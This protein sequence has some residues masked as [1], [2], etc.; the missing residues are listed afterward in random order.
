MERNE[1]KSSKPCNPWVALAWLML[2]AAGFA[3]YMMEAK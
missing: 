3:Y 2:L 1:Y